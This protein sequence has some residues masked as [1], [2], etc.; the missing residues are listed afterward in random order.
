MLF[1]HLARA[2]ASRTFWTAGSSRP[3][4][5]AMM[6]ITTNSSM[7]VNARRESRDTSLI[8]Q[9]SGR[10][11]WKNNSRLDR[12]LTN[13]NKRS[14][15]PRPADASRAAARAADAS[16][17]VVSDPNGNGRA[18]GREGELTHPCNPT[19]GGRQEK[20]R[21]FHHPPAGL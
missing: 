13:V 21:T 7:S 15:P 16:T 4:R 2:A 6:A 1:W 5:I 10:Q 17:R 3:I 20:N 12:N 11:K 14:L 9:P 8:A 19:G 18:F